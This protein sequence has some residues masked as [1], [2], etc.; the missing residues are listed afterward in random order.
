[1]HPGCV[2]PCQGRAGVPRRA[3]AVCVAVADLDG[4]PERL[5][6]RVAGIATE[7][8]PDWARGFSRMVRRFGSAWRDKSVGKADEAVLSLIEVVGRGDP[9]DLRPLLGD[10]LRSRRA[11]MR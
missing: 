4:E 5:E 8:L 11:A 7:D 3:G 10:W 2:R 6:G 1:M 9:V